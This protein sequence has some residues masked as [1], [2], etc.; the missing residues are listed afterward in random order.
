[1]SG[2]GLVGERL[3]LRPVVPLDGGEAPLGQRHRQERDDARAQRFVEGPGEEGVGLLRVAFQQVGQ[4]LGVQHRRA[5]GT[6]GAEAVE[7][8][9]GVVAHPVGPVAAHQR[10]QVGEGA[11]Q[12]V[13]VVQHTTGRCSLG[14]GRPALGVAGPSDQGVDQGAVHGDRRV[15]LDEALGGEPLHPAQHGVDPSAHPHR[16]GAAQHE[17]GDTLGVTGPLRVLDGGLRQAVRLVPAGRAAVE[18]GDDLRF[19]PQQL[20]VQQL[21]EEVVVAVPAATVRRGG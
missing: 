11:V 3:G 6:R 4:T 5:V 7:G 17:A 9:P 13:P 14:G 18:L 21:P 1:M 2:E 16:V 20:G 15:L 19:A 10:A 8:L 12:R